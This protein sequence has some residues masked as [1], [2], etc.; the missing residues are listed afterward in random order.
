MN[1]GSRAYYCG[2]P[3]LL[4]RPTAKNKKKTAIGIKGHKQKSQ[5]KSRGP[6]NTTDLICKKA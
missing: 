5:E 3:C 4:L 6:V 2:L 1:V